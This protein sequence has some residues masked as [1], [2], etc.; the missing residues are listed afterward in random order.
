MD[1]DGTYFICLQ[2]NYMGKSSRQTYYKFQYSMVTM[3][4]VFMTISKSINQFVITDLPETVSTDN[5]IY[6]LQYI[7]SFSSDM[8]MRANNGHSVSLNFGF[9]QMF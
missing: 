8:F 1:G 4:I 7:E 9:N 6:H 3:G 2:L 5:K